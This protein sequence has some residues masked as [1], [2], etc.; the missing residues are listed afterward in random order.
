MDRS[1]TPPPQFSYP[2]TPPP[3]GGLDERDGFIDPK[4]AKTK[5]KHLGEHIEGESPTGFFDDIQE[6]SDI[7]LSDSKEES[8]SL[9]NVTAPTSP[10]SDTSN[11]SI[12]TTN[13]L[14]E[15]DLL[16]SLTTPS[17]APSVTEP[18]PLLKLPLFVRQIV[19]E[20]L[21]VVPGLVCICQ[22][23]TG[24]HG[25]EESSVHPE[26]RVLLPGI[27]YGLARL[28]VDGHKIGFSCFASTN[29]N[30]LLASKEVRAEA[31]AVLYT[32][33]N[34]DIVRPSAELSPPS[35]YSVRLF[36]PGCQ[37]LVPKLNIRTRSFYDL[38]W[39]LSGG[40]ND[41]KN[42][43]RG[44]KTLTLILE[45]D[46]VSKGFARQWAKQEGEKWNVYVKR[47]QIEIAK[48][49]FAANKVAADKAKKV[50]NIPNW[51]NLRVLFHGE[52]YDQTLNGASPTVTEQAKRD[53][54]RNALVQAWELFKKGAR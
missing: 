19:Y 42:F 4:P 12:A 27:A 10:V 29:I 2:F 43:Y 15:C 37:R 1:T 45:L 3:T 40:Y 52:S 33:N 28:T 16:K 25:T 30:I 14:G 6:G 13:S 23:H 21:L 44:V 8:S 9:T 22:K 46:S 51:I 50:K 5:P 47:L 41:I 48:D 18:F 20:H 24:S 31:K 26:G 36:T 39:L 35:D 32:K 49:A 34:F 38:H 11:Q 17:E 53:E 54:L 7:E